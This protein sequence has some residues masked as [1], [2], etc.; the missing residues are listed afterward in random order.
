MV[1]HWLPSGVLS[2]MSSE[3]L[4]GGLLVRLLEASWRDLGTC[5][6]S[7]RLSLNCDVLQPFLGGLWL[8]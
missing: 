6:D 7:G 3:G 4:A 1:Q 2:V 8:S 5:G